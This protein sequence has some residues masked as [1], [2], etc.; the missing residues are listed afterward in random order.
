MNGTRFVLVIVWFC[1]AGYLLSVDPGRGALGP[2]TGWLALLFA[3]YNLVR[4]WTSQQQ[5][6]PPPPPHKRRR[7]H[8]PPPYMD[9]YNAE[10]DFNKD[11]SPDKTN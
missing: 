9:E 2:W 10:F 8:D 3:V 11:Q 5:G 7:A 6:L 1:L 4:W